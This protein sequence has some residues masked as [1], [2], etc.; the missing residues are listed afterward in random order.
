MIGADGNPSDRGLGEYWEDR[1]IEMARAYG[2]EAWPFNRLRGSTFRDKA[3]KRY[4]SPDVWLLKR[5]TKQFICEIKHKNLARNGCYGFE[6]YREESMLSIESNYRNQFGSVEALYVINNHD[7][8][9]GKNEKE[10]NILH[11]HAERLSRLSKGGHEG[12]PQFTY[13]N[14]KV[15]AQ[16]MRI[17]YYPYKMFRPIRDFLA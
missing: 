9:G 2:W 11:W 10:N 16:K 5:K 8:A 7:L 4:V 3:G 17:K 13:Y 1:F 15:S 12:Q 14:G 6:L